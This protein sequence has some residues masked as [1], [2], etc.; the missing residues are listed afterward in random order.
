MV[1]VVVVDKVH[2]IRYYLES[3]LQKGG[4]EGGRMDWRKGRDRE[5]E[6]EGRKMMAVV[7]MVVVVV[8]VAVAL[9]LLLLK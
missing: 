8:V 6:E 4:R 5:K 1:V 2:I 9:L 3:W 7:V